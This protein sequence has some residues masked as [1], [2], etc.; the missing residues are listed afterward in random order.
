MFFMITFGVVLFEF[1]DFFN[2]VLSVD[3]SDARVLQ[4]MRLMSVF[5]KQL[6]DIP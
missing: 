2:R 5:G 4:A 3:V 6:V 1:F